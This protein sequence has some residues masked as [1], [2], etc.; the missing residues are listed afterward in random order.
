MPE[1]SG[2]EQAN[3]QLTGVTQEQSGL[4]AAVDSGQLWMEAGVSEHAAQRCLQTID[5]IDHW[6]SRARVLTDRMPFGDNHDGNGAADRFA[7]A[8]QDFMKVM[9]DAQDVLKN[10]AATY[11]AAGRTV[12]EADATSAQPFQGQPE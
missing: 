2:F 4:R 5:E 1:M 10:M 6:L 9:T 12:A 8:G 11:R 3:A 7:H